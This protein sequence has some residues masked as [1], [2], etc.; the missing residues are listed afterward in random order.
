MILD[1]QLMFSEAQAVTA[2]GDTPSTNVHD[3]GRTSTAL[4]T[5]SG[6]F[7]AMYPA[8]NVLVVNTISNT[9]QRLDANTGAVLQT[10]GNLGPGGPNAHPYNVAVDN[11]GFAWVSLFLDNMLLKLWP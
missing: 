2:V 6:A 1:S 4:G 8:G 11:A 9:M 3:A 5:A 10:Y 7:D